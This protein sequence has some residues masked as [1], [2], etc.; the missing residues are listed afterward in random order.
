MTFNSIGSYFADLPIR[1]APLP[2]FQWLMR[3]YERLTVFQ[4]TKSKIDW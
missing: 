3:E 4:I 2:N 1:I